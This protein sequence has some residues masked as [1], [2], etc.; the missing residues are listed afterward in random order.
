M[1]EAKRTPTPWTITFDDDKDHDYTIRGADGE[2]IAN[3]TCYYPSAPNE[4]DAIF[5]VKAVNNHDDLLAALR[6]VRSLLEVEYHD[7]GRVACVAHASGGLRE[8]VTILDAA[9]AKAVQP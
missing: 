8:V 3:D 6:K 2:F 5:I 9:I 7:D 1:T 4:A